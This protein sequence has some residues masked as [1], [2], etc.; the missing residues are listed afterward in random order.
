MKNKII[1][2]T[3]LSFLAISSMANAEINDASRQ[4]ESILS[5]A[6]TSV[7]QGIIKAK[8][9]KNAMADKW[10]AVASLDG[11]FMKGA[12]N[13]FERALK[14][15]DD[16]LNDIYVGLSSGM[17]SPRY[18][19]ETLQKEGF[20]SGMIDNS[21]ESVNDIIENLKSQKKDIEEVL[22]DL[23]MYSFERAKKYVDEHISAVKNR[24]F[25]QVWK[26]KENPNGILF[27]YMKR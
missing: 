16:Y 1:F 4:K 15:T 5:D 18:A 20:V 10:N 26:S 12:K 21:E 25:D 8:D 19:L 17:R 13:K 9:D 23:S 6:I 24:D 27:E 22:R 3:M 14:A 7:E 11:E 2:T